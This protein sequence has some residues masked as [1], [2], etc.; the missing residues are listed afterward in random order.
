MSPKGPEWLERS[1]PSGWL[2]LRCLAACRGS[3]TPF[4]PQQ[5]HGASCP[6]YGFLPWER[7]KP[8][9]AA[10]Q[11]LFWNS[12]PTRLAQV[13]YSVLKF[14]LPGRSEFSSLFPQLIKINNTSLGSLWALTRAKKCLHAINWDKHFFHSLSLPAGQR[15]PSHFTQ[16]TQ[17]QNR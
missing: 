2:G 7:A 12:F 16:S 1:L 14:Q 6:D 11:T 5:T 9:G 13:W 10:A 17:V 3:G 15:L 4:C 8:Q